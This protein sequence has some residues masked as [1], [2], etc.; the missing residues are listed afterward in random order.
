MVFAGLVQLLVV[1]VGAAIVA[2]GVQGFK[3]EWL[4]LFKKPL[5]GV[6][7]RI[8]VYMLAICLQGYNW[9]VHGVP[10]WEFVVLAFMTAF[11][12]TGIYQFIKK[13]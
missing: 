2:A 10:T 13:R 6:T 4:A 8:F 1:L 9:Y 3:A 7:A 5:S 12:A 11:C